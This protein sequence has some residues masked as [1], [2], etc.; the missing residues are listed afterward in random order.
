LALGPRNK[1]DCQQGCLP[2]GGGG[3]GV[4]RRFAQKFFP[5][6]SLEN[7]TALETSGPKR[8]PEPPLRYKK[9]VQRGSRGKKTT[10]K[11]RNPIT[12]QKATRPRW[13]KN[14]I[15][16]FELRRSAR[17]GSGA[18]VNKEKKCRKTT[19]H[20][21][22]VGFQ[23]RCGKRR[24][25]DPT[26]RGQAA[27]R[28]TLFLHV[29]RKKTTEHT[30]PGGT[31]TA[32]AQKNIKG[33]NGEEKATGGQDGP[34]YLGP[35]DEMRQAKVNSPNAKGLVKKDRGGRSLKTWGRCLT[36]DLAAGLLRAG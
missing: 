20:R 9:I 7:I 36:R 10:R 30:S 27:G 18:V 31:F 17:G 13:G 29:R 23:T 16:T 2:S 19:G 6:C 4:H 22:T 35:D 11:R 25:A 34:R 5:C 32:Q 8:A 24:E 14:D 26:R 15:M 1:L 21:P 3:G 28:E 33:S 12:I